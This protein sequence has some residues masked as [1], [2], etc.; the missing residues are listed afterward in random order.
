MCVTTQPVLVL[1]L[2]IAELC[3]INT[4]EIDAGKMHHIL[5]MKMSM[6]QDP[7]LMLAWHVTLTDCSRP[8]DLRC[9]VKEGEAGEVGWPT[10]VCDAET[11]ER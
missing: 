4:T 1:Q 3:D 7:P 9:A 8:L 11:A 5:Y 6:L 10:F 2:H